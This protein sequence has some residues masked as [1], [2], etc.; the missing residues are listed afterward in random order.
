MQ[1]SNKRAAHRN[2]LKRIPQLTWFDFY[3]AD[4][5]EFSVVYLALELL[6]MA[7]REDER[8]IPGPLEPVSRALTSASR[9]CSWKVTEVTCNVPRDLPH[10]CC[11]F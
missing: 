10:D 7:L 1:R 4:Q 9:W 2:T 5:V 8:R 3:C 6:S 11:S